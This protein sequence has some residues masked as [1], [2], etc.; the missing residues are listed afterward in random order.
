MD[1]LA[2]L[3]AG[4][5]GS[6]AFVLR[7]VLAAP[8][9]IQLDDRA[10]L[11]VMVVIEGEVWL[12]LDD[13][14]AG[15]RRLGAG[16]CAILTASTTYRIGDDVGSPV[17]ARIAPGQV[18]SKPD[19]SPLSDFRDLGV[20]SWGN[21]ADDATDTVLLTGSY[22]GPGQ[23]GAG[24]LAVLPAAIVAPAAE[25]PA[26][27]TALVE[28][29]S[30]EAGRDAPG[31]GAVLD[32]LVDLLAVALLRW[33]LTGSNAPAWFTAQRDPVV[34]AALRCIH[35]EPERPWTVAGLAAEALV[36]RAV[37]ARRFHELVGV[38]P[39]AYLAGWRLDVAADLL[40]TSD[41]TVEAVANRVGYGSPF[42]FSA[43][44][45]RRFGRSPTAHRRSVR[46]D[47]SVGLPMLAG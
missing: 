38:P 14:S 34:G 29:L 45:S 21:A 2:A 7:S 26:T 25:V 27:V 18:C 1:A 24:L 37:L 20:R 8:W 33:Y 6:G 35:H 47:P 4:P 10:P 31:Q 16:D 44:F 23:V 39:M 28:L 30:A 40:S 19:G 17:L 15:P 5:H 13:G 3:L 41:L 9:A 42:S 43:A 11:S 22:A 36:S 12:T 32:R 46:P